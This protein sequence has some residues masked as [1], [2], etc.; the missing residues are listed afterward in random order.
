MYIKIN[1]FF[2]YSIEIITNLEK[3]KQAI[4]EVTEIEDFTISSISDTEGD[5]HNGASVRIVE[6]L[7][8]EKVV[9]K[10]RS[11]ATPKSWVIKITV[12]WYSF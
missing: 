8:G 1:N 5:T 4:S 9:Y 6:L 12:N 11:L 3:D 10:P 7:N 2:S